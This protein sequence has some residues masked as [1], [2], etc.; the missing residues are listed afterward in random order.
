MGEVYEALDESSGRRVALKVMGNRLDSATDRRRFLREGRLS[1]AVSHPNAVYIFGSEEIDDRPVIVMELVRAGTLKERVEKDGPLPVSEAVDAILQIID[2]L[3]A[4]A[5]AGVL[6]RDVKP[7]NCFVD[8]DG[9]VKIGDFGLS[10]STQAR[11]ESMLTATGTLMGTPSFASPE[12]LRGEPLDVAS[13][14]Y[15][16]GATLYYLLAGRT[17][18]SGKEL[19]HL[20]TQVL[21][22]QPEPVHLARPEVP[23]GLSRVVARCLAKSRNARFPDYDSLRRAFR[24][25]SSAADSPATVARRTTAGFVD[26]LVLMGVTMLPGMAD[27]P[28]GLLV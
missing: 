6:H 8:A 25:W 4:A 12:Q 22:E 17:P 19:V 27:A 21:E 5:G 14:I 11:P 26:L 23:R 1:A 9:T 15:G 20:I 28:D 16:V 24:P 2:G 3:E 7:A 13:D 10:I 18:H